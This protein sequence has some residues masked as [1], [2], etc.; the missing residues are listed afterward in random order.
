M[1]FQILAKKRTISFNNDNNLLESSS[2]HKHVKYES[3]SDKSKSI[4]EYINQNDSNAL[5]SDNSLNV[6]SDHSNSNPDLLSLST[7][8]NNDQSKSSLSYNSLRYFVVDPLLIKANDL[9]CSLCLR[10]LYNP[11]T[12]PCGHT[13]CCSCLER[14][15]DHQDRCPLCKDSLADVLI[16]N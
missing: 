9:E 8:I 14:S 7:E 12:T 6:H 2:S 16:I 11:V 5:S 13:F 4:G 15:L 3:S 10:L 1:F